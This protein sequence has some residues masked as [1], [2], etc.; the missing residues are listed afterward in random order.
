MIR[1]VEEKGVEHTIDVSNINLK[2]VILNSSTSYS[3]DLKDDPEILVSK[4]L[5]KEE[6]NITNSDPLL[7]QLIN[8]KLNDFLMHLYHVELVF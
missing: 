8:V 4:E 5:E 7:K 1:Y 2:S 6:K 3:K